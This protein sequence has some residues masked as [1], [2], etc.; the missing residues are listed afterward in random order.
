MV[1]LDK[2]VR[3]ACFMEPGSI[4]AFRKEAPMISKYVCF[5]NEN[6]VQLGSNNLHVMAPY[7]FLFHCRRLFAERQV[8]VLV[9]NQL[10]CMRP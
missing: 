2:I 10:V 5:Y 7:L 6:A 3:Y 8:E 9:A 4:V 1:I